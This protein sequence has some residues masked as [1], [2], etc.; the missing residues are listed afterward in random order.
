MSGASEEERDECTAVENTTLSRLGNN[1]VSHM[2]ECTSF[3]YLKQWWLCLQSTQGTKPRVDEDE[4][5]LR[6]GS[7]L[8]PRDAFKNQVSVGSSGKFTIQHSE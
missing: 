2:N 7:G 6:T 4:P 8:L 1:C 3:N 5:L